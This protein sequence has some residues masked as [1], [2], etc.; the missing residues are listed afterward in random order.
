MEEVK[1][2]LK[3]KEK[4]NNLLQSIVIKFKVLII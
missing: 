1:I 4:L 2:E 3:I